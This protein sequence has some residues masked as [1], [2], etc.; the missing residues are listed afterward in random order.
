MRSQVPHTVCIVD[1]DSDIRE[2]MRLVL[3]LRGYDVLEASDGAE[4][5]EVM[6]RSDAPCCLVLLDLMMPGM[7]G[8]EFRARQR[9][10]PALASVPVV[11][12][13][14]VREVASQARELD[15]SEVLQK[16]IDLEQLVSIVERHC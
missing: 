4:A 15:A 11:V 7:N 2:A 6:R 10:D 5:L 12:L 9:A 16:P 1:D 13:S 3:E 14:G 8:W